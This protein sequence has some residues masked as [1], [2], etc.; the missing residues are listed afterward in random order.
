V[1]FGGISLTT[2]AEFEI[3]YHQFLDAEGNLSASA[4]ALAKDRAQLIK[5]YRLMSLV[6]TFDK[7]AVNLQR[8]GK[9]G[10][11]ASCLGHEATHVGV[12][13]GVAMAFKIR[14]EARCS[15]PTS[16]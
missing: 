5:M 2:V 15:V 7:K 3:K 14:G 13:A 10:A 1:A 6:R 16:V 9:L 12:G 8:T 4:P 11:Y